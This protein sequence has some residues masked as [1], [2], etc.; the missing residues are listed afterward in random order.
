VAI[1]YLLLGSNLGQKL[2]NL[3]SAENEICQRIGNLIQKSSIYKS[4]PWGF[5]HNED[6]LNQVLQIKTQHS[7]DYLLKVILGIERD[8]GRVRSIAKD[9]YLPRIIDIDILFYNGLIIETEK[10]VIQNNRY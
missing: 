7:P 5:E 9:V 2:N 10:L 1:A 6:F 8:L 4:P 3:L